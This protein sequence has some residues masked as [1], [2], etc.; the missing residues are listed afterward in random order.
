MIRQ[1]LG[2]G[3]L[4]LQVGSIVRCQTVETRFLCWA[5][6]NYMTEYRLDV[7]IQGRALT[8]AEI[9]ARY[10]HAAHDVYE[11]AA[12]NLI[13]MLQQYEET[14]GRSEGATLVLRYRVN[15]GPEQVWRWPIR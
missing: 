7:R 4:L 3:F 12:A 5:P 13:A 9:Q 8:P 6:Y 2:I 11:N 1:S 15:R 10:H 14:Y